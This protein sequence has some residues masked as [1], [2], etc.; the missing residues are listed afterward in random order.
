MSYED[1]LTACSDGDDIKVT[2][3]LAKCNP[4]DLPVTGM[5]EKA[6]WGEHSNVIQNLLAF[7]PS[8][9]AIT[10]HVLRGAI[11]SGSISAF[12]VL[13]A[14]DPN[15]LNNEHERRGTPLA[16]AASA[17]ASQEYLSFSQK[18]LILTSSVS[19]PPF[20]RLPGRLQGT[21]HSML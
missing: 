16:I 12:K 18:V 13:Y 5:L 17:K 8:Y 20:L 4:L 10:D 6:A 7:D 19:I 9:T 15:I 2:D 3:L 14:R 11:Y 1:V 21:I